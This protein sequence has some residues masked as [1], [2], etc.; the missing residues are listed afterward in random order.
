M[1]NHKSFEFEYDAINTIFFEGKEA[2]NIQIRPLHIC[3]FCQF[4][5]R[6]IYYCNSSKSTGKETGKTHLCAL[7]EKTK[8]LQEIL[9]MKTISD[10]VLPTTPLS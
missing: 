4:P 6:W 9:G 8:A 5:F 2:I 3:A 7:A 10:I 1:D